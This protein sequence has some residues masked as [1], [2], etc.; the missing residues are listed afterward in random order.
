M[1]DQS[2]RFLTGAHRSEMRDKQ[3]PV[4]PQIDHGLKGLG[5][6][7]GSYLSFGLFLSRGTDP[8]LL[9]QLAG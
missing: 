6:I 9:A 3:D 8:P 1:P 2:C 4:I 7:R 5:Y